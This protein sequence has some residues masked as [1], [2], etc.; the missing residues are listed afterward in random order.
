MIKYTLLFFAMISL[1]AMAQITNQPLEVGSDAPRIQAIDQH[2]NLLDSDKVL[3]EHK[4]LVVFYRGY[5][6][7]YCRKHLASLQDNLVTLKK[8]NVEVVVITPESLEKT[9]S[10][11][12][13]IEAEFA[14]IHDKENK[15]MNDYRVGFEVGPTTAPSNYQRTLEKMSTYQGANTT[16]PIPATY[17]IDQSGKVQFVHFDPDYKKRANLDDLL[18][19]L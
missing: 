7:P 16:L 17:L 13:S 6:C 18:K 19:M 1:T 10:T 3:K 11:S 12:A 5:W 2:G 4:M 14:I 9:Q 15:I 8:K